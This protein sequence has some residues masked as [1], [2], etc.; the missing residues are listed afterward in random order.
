MIIGALSDA[1]TCKKTRER[2]PL[3]WEFANIKQHRQDCGFGTAKPLACVASIPVPREGV[4]LHSGCTKIKARAT[5]F[6]LF[7]LAPFFARPECE[8]S[9]ERPEFRSRRSGTLATQATKH[10]EIFD[11]RPLFQIRITSFKEVRN[12][13]LISN[14]ESV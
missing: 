2:T 12:Q 6:H 7:A 8:N 3:W 14:D 10:L 5:S 9:F 4:F 11:F 13:L 1:E